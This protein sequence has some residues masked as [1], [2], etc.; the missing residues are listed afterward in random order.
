MDKEELKRITKEALKEWLDEKILT[1]GKWSLSTLMAA[2][3]AALIYF[4]L[5]ANGWQKSS[6]QIKVLHG[7]AQH[8]A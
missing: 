1:F 3:L 8:K 6:H 4:I 5:W 2:L 7:G